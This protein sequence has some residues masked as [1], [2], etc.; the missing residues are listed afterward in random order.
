MARDKKQLQIFAPGAEDP[1]KAFLEAMGITTLICAVMAAVGFQ[2][3]FFPDASQTAKKP[4]P[5]RTDGKTPL[6]PAEQISRDL[7]EKS[8]AELEQVEWTDEKALAAFEFGPRLASENA[9]EASLKNLSKERAAMLQT[10]LDERKSFAPR[11]CLVRAWFNK[12]LDKHPEL[13]AEVDEYWGE[14]TRFEEAD[15]HI[16]LMVNEYRKTRDRPEDPRYYRWLRHCAMHP[17][18]TSWRPCVEAV[19]Q[20]SPMQ[21]GD[22]LGM[23]EL[24]LQK[25]P[26]PTPQEM[27]NLTETLALIAQNGQPSFWKLQKDIPEEEYTTQ[28]KLASTFYLCRI[29]NSPVQHDAIAAADALGDLANVS[30]RGREEIRLARW[31]EACR[32]TYGGKRPDLELVDD[33]IL[34]D[35]NVPQLEVWNGVEG[36]KPEYS[37]SAAVARGLC[38]T[39]PERP[40]WYCGV[41]LWRE[42]S[43]SIDALVKR[44]FVDTRYLE[45][46][47]Q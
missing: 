30:S 22:M 37:M 21:G 46:T 27:T 33:P 26:L 39:E 12:E 35:N 28:M 23:I 40:I 18:V 45:W 43:M 8:E 4:A 7:Q 41:K 36:A 9:C 1:N 2:Y 42:P 29:V 10:T 25:V 34:A 3:A 6:S 31:R 14:V 24:H 17:G 11:I 5:T 19:R 15:M 13:V 47:N 32:I 16:T 44:S 38:Q 20:L